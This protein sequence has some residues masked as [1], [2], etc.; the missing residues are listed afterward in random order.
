M[1]TRESTG[2]MKLDGVLTVLDRTAK[3]LAGIESRKD[4][5]AWGSC[6]REALSNL[7]EATQE[8]KKVYDAAAV[9]RRVGHCPVSSRELELLVL[10]MTQCVEY[11][12]CTFACDE[13][14]HLIAG[15]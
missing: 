9:V 14:S 8:L 15:V 11:G 12:R 13:I 4:T 10:H 3:D 2:S 7:E 1:S 6:L 5:R